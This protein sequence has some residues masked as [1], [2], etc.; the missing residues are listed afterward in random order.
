MLKSADRNLSA[1]A[2]KGAKMM[3]T[4]NYNL[5][6]FAGCSAFKSAIRN[7]QSNARIPCAKCR[8]E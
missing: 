1:I 8:G 7:P 6:S 5:T 3:P 2:T 4:Q